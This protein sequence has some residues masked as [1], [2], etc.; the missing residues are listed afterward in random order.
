MTPLCRLIVPHS[1][2]SLGSFNQ[3]QRGA[4]AELMH[5]HGCCRMLRSLLA[6]GQTQ[7]LH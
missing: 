5:W 1:R 2:G 4:H 3:A 6:E 7:K